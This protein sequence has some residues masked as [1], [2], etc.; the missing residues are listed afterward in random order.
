M[1]CAFNL[2]R[3]V[4]LKGFISGCQ[5]DVPKE[6]LIEFIG[7]VWCKYH[8]PVLGGDE[9]KSEKA[10]WDDETCNRFNSEIIEWIKTASGSSDILDLSGVVFPA[11]IDFRL[12]ARATFGINSIDFQHAR[13][14]S[15]VTF[16]KTVFRSVSN[17]QNCIF[18]GDLRCLDARFAGSANFF[19]AH[20]QGVVYFQN[21]S[22]GLGIFSNAVFDSTANFNGTTGSLFNFSGCYFGGNT[23]FGALKE[24]DIPF[25]S[26]DH[27]SFRSFTNFNNRYFRDRTIFESATFLVAPSFHNCRLHQDTN[28][29]DAEFLDTETG[30]AARAYRTLKL[31]MEGHRAR[32]EQANF[33]ALEQQSLRKQPDTSWA[34]KAT[35]MA[36]EVASDYGR[37]FHRPLWLL[38]GLTTLVAGAYYRFIPLAGGKISRTEAFYFAIEQVVR[39]FSVWSGS[40]QAN[41]SHS[42]QTALENS[43]LLI[44]ML[45]SAQSLLSVG[46]V[47]LSILALRRRF[48][49]D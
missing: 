25:A 33:Y 26:F 12:P 42:L 30:G 22:L 7:E 19:S 6:N 23:D 35:S 43:P 34:L 13:F 41:I 16:G 18:E 39:P 5:F 38:A 17:F 27:A 40:Y 11:K 44:P 9:V 28:F 1:P 10:N 46:L 37:N 3:G 15:D 29:S 49:M 47:A 48:K 36:Y 31:A 4:P 21:A 45:A 20:F 32:D 14:C 24:T 2:K 8:L